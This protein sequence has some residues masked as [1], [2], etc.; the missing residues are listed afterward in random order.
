MPTPTESPSVA[1]LATNFIPP[2]YS[3][4]AWAGVRATLD[5]YTLELALA[6]VMTD[7]TIEDFREFCRCLRLCETLYFQNDRQE[8]GRYDPGARYIVNLARHVVALIDAQGTA[9]APA[10]SKVRNGIEELHIQKIEHRLETGVSE[11]L[12]L[13]R[14]TFG[15]TWR[16]IRALEWGALAPA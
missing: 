15:E 1:P 16:P 6:R 11:R 7:Q 3:E 14:K 4:L 8:P 2:E 9:P 13:D 12:G 5:L 10:L